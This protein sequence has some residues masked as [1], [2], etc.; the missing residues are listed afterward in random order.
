M[1]ETKLSSSGVV[2][3]NNFLFSSKSIQPQKKEN[4]KNN[5]MIISSASSSYVSYVSVLIDFN[6]NFF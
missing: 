5:N 3:T 1:Q 2:E 6:F 4:L